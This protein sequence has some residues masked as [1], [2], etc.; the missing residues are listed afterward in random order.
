[1]QIEVSSLLYK[2]YYLSNKSSVKISQF[3]KNF[4][5]VP[6]YPFLDAGARNLAGHSLQTSASGGY[7]LGGG[8]GGFFILGK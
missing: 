5:V 3:K 7:F 6:D 1:M 8:F 2:F 4:A